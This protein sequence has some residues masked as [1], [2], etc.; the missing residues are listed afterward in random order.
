MDFRLPATSDSI[1]VGAIEFPD[2]KNMGVA[3]GISVLCV[4]DAEILL[5]KHVGKLQ[6]KIFGFPEIDL[7]ETHFYLKNPQRNL[8]SV[9]ARMCAHVLVRN[10]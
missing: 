4:M 1:P 6:L 5:V 10:T 8:D 2:P 7:M 3:F 9:F